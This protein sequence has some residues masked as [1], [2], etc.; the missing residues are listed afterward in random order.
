MKDCIFC[1]IARQE[2]PTP[3]VYDGDDVVAFDDIAPIA[4]VH[5]LV[6]PKKHVA[7]LNDVADDSAQEA[8]CAELLRA[9]AIVA[10]RR[11]IAASGYKVLIRTGADGGQ[12]VPHVHVHVI[13][14]APL[15]EDIHPVQ[16]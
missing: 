7:S 12:E 10:R 2:V 15:R 6:V 3:L 5:V 13:G 8:V 11:G 9:A 16:S 14:G 4:P 1:K